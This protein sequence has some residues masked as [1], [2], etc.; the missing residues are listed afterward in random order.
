M[1]IVIA[2]DSFKGCLGSVE[3]G[4]AIAEGVRR[5]LPDSSVS[6][7]PISDGGEGMA[8]SLL[9][10]TGSRTVTARAHDPLGRPIECSYT[11]IDGKTAVIETA[12]AAGLPLLSDSERD[13]MHTTTAGVGELILDAAERGCRSFIIG[14]GGS[15]T[16]DGGAGMLQALGVKMT[17]GNGRKI[18][19]G[20]AG[21]ETIRS[22][23]TS[24]LSPLLDGC[25]FS[26]ACD[27]TNPLCGKLGCSE[28]FAPQKGADTNSVR[29]MDSWLR[30]YAE[31]MRRAEPNADPDL[32][33]TGAAGGMGFALNAVLDARLERGIALI[34]RTTGLARA[35]AEADIVVTGEGRLDAQSIMGKVPIG[36]ADEARKHGVPVI[37]IA[38]AVS[39]DAALCNEHGISAFFPALRRPCTTDEALEPDTARTNLAD[40]AEQVFNL[41]RT[42]SITNKSTDI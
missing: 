27:V 41:I 20:A 8:A 33:G 21:L 35:I 36:I 6:V 31:C 15:A 25:S 12:A 7:Y 13:P 17:D 42:V 24:S 29:L 14:L 34:I 2:T 30:G 28:V 10:V 40:T 11:V 26:A 39:H 16:N 37:A 32:P 3:A 5:A 4:N 9:S 1:N 23:D 19:P 22:I 18:C 38:G